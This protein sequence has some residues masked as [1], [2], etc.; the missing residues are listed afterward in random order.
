MSAFQDTLQAIYPGSITMSDYIAKTSA[1]LLALGFDADNTQACASVCRDEI[2]QPFVAAIQQAWGEAFNLSSLAGMLFCG[3]TGLHAALGHAPLVNGRKRCV[4]FVFAHIGIDA[5]GRSG[6][7]VRKGH[8]QA[9]SA[10][11][12]LAGFRKELLS[13]C[14]NLERDPDDVEQS[15]IK[16]RFIK[17]IPHNEVPKLHVLTAMVEQALVQDIE[18]L[19]GF[20]GDPAVLDY[21]V[22]TGMQIH[23]PEQ[24]YIRPGLAYAVTRGLRHEI[25]AKV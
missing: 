12:A 9:S 2:T 21:A 10:C 24:E 8:T 17:E 3:K 23:G 11:G 6:Y 20:T 1:E 5:Q 16:R 7:H 13:G 4:F 14:V 15:L 22:L 19:I 25:Y 18:R